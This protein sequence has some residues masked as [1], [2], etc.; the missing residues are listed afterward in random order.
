MSQRT[1]VLAL[2]VLMVTLPAALADP[3]RL[4]FTRT[5]EGLFEFDTS[6]LKGRLKLDGKYQGIYPLIDVAT[7]KQLVNPPGIFSFY[8]VFSTNRRYGDAAR[9]WPTIPKLLPDGAV[10]VHWPPADEHP[11]EMTAVYRWRAADTL[12]L[13]ISL[14]PQRDMSGFELF[15]SSYFRETFRAS[16]Y[17][18]GD[19]SSGEKP[20]FV[21]VDR[22]SS[23]RGRFVTFPRDEAALETIHDG[24]WT[25]PPSPI[26]WAV[27]RWLAAPLAI[28]RDEANGLTA[29]MMCPPE[30]CFAVSSPWNPLTPQ[31]PGYRSLYLSLFGR[32]LKA[33]QTVRARCR[34][35]ISREMTDERAERYYG[36]YLDP[37]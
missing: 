23:S 28:R 37:K 21:A 11:I 7:G 4:A 19:T 18:Q 14:K 3:P 2:F 25:I 12:D 22:P 30:D 9:D 34:L 31:A 36:E 35:V 6:E 32:D 27:K 1:G 15:I 26:D 17:M 8:R 5:G 13:E 16:V 33:G 20:R 10:Q 24:R 29:L